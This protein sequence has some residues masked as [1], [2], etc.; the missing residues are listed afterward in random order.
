MGS[1]VSL[2]MIDSSQSL[3]ACP[4]IEGDRVEHAKFGLGTVTTIGDR[5]VSGP[6]DPTRVWIVEVVFD[7]GVGPKRLIHTVLT[8][9]GSPEVR[10]FI[11]WDKQWQV[12]R[13][14]WLDARRRH[15]E[16]L[17]AFRPPPQQSDVERLRASEHLALEAL[18]AFVAADAERRNV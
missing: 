7:D 12:L 9:V 15:E 5:S 2:N 1:E 3:P 4:L 17:A 13:R 16:A 8:K 11:F 18:D 14:A 10:P 6:S